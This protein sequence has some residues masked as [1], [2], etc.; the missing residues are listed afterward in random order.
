LAGEGWNFVDG[1][2]GNDG[3]L[4]GSGNDIL[5]GGRGDDY[6]RGGGGDD[7]YTFNRGDGADLVLDG[8]ELAGTPSTV[9]DL[10]EYEAS[11]AWRIVR[12]GAVPEAVIRSVA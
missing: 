7:T 3:I 9:I 10:S 11:G 1:G 4:S 8:G 6:L 5:Y 2:G 12:Q